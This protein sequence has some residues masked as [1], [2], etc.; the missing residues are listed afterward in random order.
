VSVIAAGVFNSGVLADIDG[1]PQYNY[2]PAPPEIVSRARTLAEVC[3]R[4]EVPLK[5]AAL[6]FPLAHPAVATALVGCRTPEEIVQNVDLLRFE[7]PPALWD[8]LKAER[9]LAE[10]AP[11]PEGPAL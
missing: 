5:A 7:I 9:L 3:A 6:Q 4:H 8:E 11:T 1:S 10:E 2:A